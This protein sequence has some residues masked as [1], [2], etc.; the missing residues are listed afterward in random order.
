DSNGTY[1][2]DTNDE[3][4]Y[5]RYKQRNSQLANNKIY[6]HQ[7]NLPP[8]TKSIISA[9]IQEIPKEQLSQKPSPYVFNNDAAKD[10][11]DSEAPPIALNFNP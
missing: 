2:S 4:N 11:D 7:R 6:Q 8:A 3:I 9:E 10:F 5:S 1:K